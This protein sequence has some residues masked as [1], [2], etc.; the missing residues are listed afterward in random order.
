MTDT[1]PQAVEID[2]A[3]RR[4]EVEAKVRVP[5]KEAPTLGQG[6]TILVLL[7]SI[8][9][10]VFSIYKLGEG[11]IGSFMASQAYGAEAPSAGFWWWAVVLVIAWTLLGFVNIQQPNSAR[12]FTL[13]GNYIGTASQTGLF[14]V[15][16]PFL[17]KHQH[18]LAQANFESASLKINDKRGNPLSVS[19]IVVYRVNKPAQATFSVENYKSYLAIQVEAAL[20]HAV[21]EFPYSSNKEGEA[22]LL[23]DSDDINDQLTA[24]VAA[25]VSV[26]GLEIVEARINNL[27]FSV[28]IAQ[29]MLQV[30]QAEAI[31]DARKVLVEGSIGIVEDAIERLGSSADGRTPT[32]LTDEQRVKLTTNLLTVLVGERSAQPVIDL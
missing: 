15:P 1:T 22:S 14:M 29:A 25:A 3:A 21:S 5:E 17:A 9:G 7:L 28:E 18:S 12:V 31:L 6:P 2:R 4:T 10:L 32:P 20:R 30:Q 26:A 24:E 19:A 13:F 8:V 23:R 16:I 11:V 27:A